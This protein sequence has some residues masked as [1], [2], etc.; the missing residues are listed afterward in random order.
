MH[1]ASASQAAGLQ[2]IA[3]PAAA[4]LV[5][6]VHH[7]ERS[8]EL[9]LLWELCAA[10][11]GLGYSLALLDACSTESGANPGL[12]QM[13]ECNFGPHDALETT[14]PWA[15]YPAAQGLQQLQGLGQSPT[16]TLQQLGALLPG[17]GVV[18]LYAPGEV[19]AWLLADTGTEPLVV[20][21]G[22]GAA[23]LSAY[24]AL[25]QLLLDGALK[26]TIASLN[27]DFLPDNP[28]RLLAPI[29]TVQACAA[30]FLGFSPDATT[31][32]CGGNAQSGTAAS[33]RLALRLLE[34]AVQLPTNSTDNGWQAPDRSDP[35]FIGAH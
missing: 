24:Q 7:C 28:G 35:G 13:L 31:I 32:S 33:E 34:G 25:K 18:V 2:S 3:C 15:I 8:D 1:D 16:R 26:P 20:L 9:P 19:V 11:A 21:P 17:F 5:A 30:N 22:G 4:R 29:R 27:P 14:T 10:I 6:I 12:A 23:M